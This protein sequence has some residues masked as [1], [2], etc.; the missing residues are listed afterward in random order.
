MGLT[1]KSNKVLAWPASTECAVLLFLAIAALAIPGTFT[2]S[3]AIYSSPPFLFLLGAFSLNLLLCTLKRLKTISKA[4]LVLHV[5]VLLTLAGCIVTSFGYVATVN[6][7]EGTSVNRFYRWDEQQDVDLG[8]DLLVKKINSEYYPIPVKVGVLKG[9]NKEQLFE[10]KTGESFEYG[11]YRITAESFDPAREQLNLAV[12]QQGRRIGSSSTSGAAELPAD[13]PYS[14]VLVAFQNPRLKRLWVDL[15]VQRNSENVAE[16]TSE[17]NG[18]FTWGGLYF[19]NTQTGKDADGAP[20]AG[21]QIVRDPGRPLVFAG[22]AVMG[23]GAVLSYLR[24]VISRR[25]QHSIGD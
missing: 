15:A 12:Y 8:F 22:F 20:F 16:G 3:R 17:V 7:Y 11:G 2:E 10:L 19:Y 25:K 24:R 5:G 18:P 6:I 13:F 1:E 21:I 14:F 4:V 23:L 9:Q